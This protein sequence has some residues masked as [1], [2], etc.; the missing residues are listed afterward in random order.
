MNVTFFLDEIIWFYSTNNLVLI[1]RQWIN[2]VFHQVIP[3]WIFRTAVKFNK[4]NAPP[5][6]SYPK[7]S[8]LKTETSF[9][10][11][12][13]ELHL[14]LKY[15]IHLVLFCHIKSIKQT[16]ENIWGIVYSFYLYAAVKYPKNILKFYLMIR[17]FDKF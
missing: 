9:S 15:L 14:E 6:I 2:S 1:G 16:N 8:T 5:F 11:L 13:E 17:S 3:W 10:L 7:T 12:Y 4:S